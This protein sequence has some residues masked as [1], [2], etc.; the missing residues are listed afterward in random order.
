MPANVGSGGRG[1]PSDHRS[2]LKDP[3]LR[4]RPVLLVVSS[5]TRPQALSLESGKPVLVRKKI[6]NHRLGGGGKVECVQVG[7]TK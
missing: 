1:S 5:I 6:F 7:V 4:L 3:Q 2:F